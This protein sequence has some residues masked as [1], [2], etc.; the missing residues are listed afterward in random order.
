MSNTIPTVSRPMELILGTA[1]HIDH[2]KTSLIRALTGTDTDRLPEEK[3]RGITIELGYAW[4]DM[5]SVQFGIVDVPGHEKFVRQMLA[6][7]T[8]MDMVML[9]VAADDSVKQQ[10]R[11][12]LDV[13]QFLRIPAGIVVLTKCDTADPDWITLVEGEVRELVR[14]TFLH[15]A[16][17]VRTSS[18]TGLGL[19]TLRRVLVETAQRLAANADSERDKLA[20]RMPIDRSFSV[21]GHGTVVTGSIGSG[22]AHVGDTFWLAPDGG[23]VR[24]RGLHHHDRPV[25]EVRRGQRAAFNL[26]GVHH[27]TVRP[28][29]E[30]CEVGSFRA[31]QLLTVQLQLLPHLA[32]PLK[33]R[34]TVRLHLG[35]DEWIT[36]IQLLDRTEVSPGETALV[37][38][39]LPRSALVAWGQPLVIRQSSPMCTIGGGR[40]LS[41][42]VPAWRKLTA[43]SLQHLDNLCSEQPEIR[44][45]AVI[46]L[47]GLQHWDVQ[48][49][50]SLSGVPR[51]QI[52]PLMSQMCAEQSL[53][54]IVHSANRT[55]ML[56]VDTLAD[57]GDR[58]EQHLR[59]AHRH[60][61]RSS[62]LDRSAV[63]DR[64]RFDGDPEILQEIVAR[65]VTQGRLR[66][67]RSGI[68]LTEFAPRIST[69]EKKLY[70]VLI[71]RFQTAGLQPPTV[72]ECRDATTR[73]REAV[74]DLLKL[75]VAE[76]DLIQVS[77]EMLLHA[78]VERDAREL[79]RA[80]LRSGGMSVSQIRELLQ[81]SRRYAV[82]FCEY[83]DRAG[84]TVRAGDL[85]VLGPAGG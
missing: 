33:H 85:R 59:R 56:H 83:L 32:R 24:V 34:A 4:L 20:F 23:E 71:Q 36:R 65:L 10:T 5:G 73:N 48:E 19:D 14:G 52:E 11:E 49:L 69:N 27:R 61:P 58:F 7:A 21:A 84:F 81:T 47:M 76:G 38:M 53:V 67:T 41:P 62:L 74:E 12:H 18:Q 22:R 26:V 37:Q 1:G 17:V 75:A 51:R 29:Q 43:R 50:E 25:D 82:P 46:Q 66:W 16:P 28:G 42:S 79:L 3:R 45:A 63:M 6:G 80:P 9:V 68:G 72:Q 15:D 77:A 64:F 57:I 44:L 55:S 30:L 40:V 35:T 39:M 54:Q 70:E 2:G 8:G 13:L 31:S 78:Q 60:H